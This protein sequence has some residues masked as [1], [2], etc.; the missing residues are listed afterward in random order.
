MLQEREDPGLLVCATRLLN[1]EIFR[2]LIQN[3][4]EV[5][6]LA[7]GQKFDQLAVP[8]LGPDSLNVHP[9]AKVFDYYPSHLKCNCLLNQLLWKTHG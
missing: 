6:Q 2:Q 4:G 1:S 7:A 9:V 8:R 3:V 5:C